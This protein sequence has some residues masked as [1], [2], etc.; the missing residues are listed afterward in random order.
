MKVNIIANNHGWGLQ[1]DS[2]ILTAYLQELGHEVNYAGWSDA[3]P[4][5]PRA[6]INI[7][8]EVVQPKF[9]RFAKRQWLIPNPEWLFKQWEPFFP[10][11]QYV[12]CKTND[13]LRIMTPMMGDKAVY[14]GFTCRDMYDSSVPK[15][16]EFLHLAG[17]SLTKG[18]Q[19]I[20]SAWLS[21]KIT[22]PLHVIS[23]RFRVASTKHMSSNTSLSEYSIKQLMNSCAFHLCPSQ[24]EGYG[25]ALH[26][27]QSAYAVTLTTDAPPMN[28]FSSPF[29]VHPCLTETKE[30]AI[31]HKVSAGAIVE[32]VEQMLQLTDAELLTKGNAARCVFLNDRDFFRRRFKE[33]L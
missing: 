25:H 24:Y 1:R 17:D 9:F 14:T 29:L 32:T 20:I 2:E 12:L 23:R 6:A 30:Y 10:E 22:A 16:R 11:F 13:A 31:L 15:K 27:A 5:L 4:L 3:V 26:E 7:F 18:T 19:P 21:K 8:C 28:E 33:L